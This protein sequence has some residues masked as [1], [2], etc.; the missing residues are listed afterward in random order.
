MNRQENGMNDQV[1]YEW[2]CDPLAS[3]ANGSTHRIT[4]VAGIR[5]RHLYRTDYSFN[6]DELIVLA[7]ERFHLSTEDLA[8][9]N[10]MLTIGLMCAVTNAMADHNKHITKQHAI[11]AKRSPRGAH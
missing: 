11:L 7:A 8:D 2:S 10:G 9:E 1:E 6:L 3:N 5:P 4:L